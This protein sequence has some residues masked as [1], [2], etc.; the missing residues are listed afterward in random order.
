MGFSKLGSVYLLLNI[1]RGVKRSYIVAEMALKVA[2]NKKF[3]WRLRSH[4]HS[5]VRAFKAFY[6]VIRCTAITQANWLDLT[7]VAQEIVGDHAPGS[8]MVFDFHHFLSCESF[9]NLIVWLT[10]ED[11]ISFDQNGPSFPEILTAEHNLKTA[12]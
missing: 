4:R 5:W 1:V 12:F 10:I 6:A 9:I 8:F 11:T 3:M 7:D 2:K